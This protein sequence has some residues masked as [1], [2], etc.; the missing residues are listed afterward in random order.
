MPLKLVVIL[1]WACA[2]GANAY[3][4]GEWE[5]LDGPS[6]ARAYALLDYDGAVRLATALGVHRLQAERWTLEHSFGFN[7]ARATAN[8]AYDLFPDPPGAFLVATDTGVFRVA[9]SVSTLLTLS[10]GRIHAVKVRKNAGR[11]LFLGR[12]PARL[13]SSP[14]GVNWDIA[15]EG[16]LDFDVYQSQIWLLRNV[17]EGTALFREGGE[18][19]HFGQTFA[20]AKLYLSGN[21][22]AVATPSGL[23]ISEDG[24]QNFSRV[25][26]EAGVS[27]Y[28]PNGFLA[29]EDGVV[30]RNDNNVWTPVFATPVPAKIN[31]FVGQYMLCDDYFGVYRITDFTPLND[32]LRNVHV[33]AVGE[34]GGTVYAFATEIGMYVAGASGNGAWGKSGTG[35]PFT[36]A[37]TLICTAPQTAFLFSALFKSLY[38]TDNRGALWRKVEDFPA[39]GYFTRL[40][41]GKFYASDDSTLFV[42]DNGWQWNV[43]SRPGT[44]FGGVPSWAGDTLFIVKNQKLHY[45]DGAWR[46]YLTLG[47]TWNPETRVW[48]KSRVEFIHSR[49]HGPL[50]RKNGTQW[51]LQHTSV[52]AVAA[53]AGGERLVFAAGGKL[54][55]YEK[56]RRT[57]LDFPSPHLVGALTY[58]SD[59]KR[60]FVGTYEDGLYALGETVSRT[61]ETA[62]PW[63]RVYPNPTRD[64]LN[65][66]ARPGHFALI[67]N[68][69]GAVVDRFSID[70]SV[71]RRDVSQLPAGVY[72][73]QV[74][75]TR[76]RWVKMQAYRSE[77]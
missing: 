64:E 4:Q 77:P 73:L 37:E 12:N 5:G 29:T 58:S 51:T 8:A 65:I 41:D 28:S 11:F 54:Y 14:N 3:G 23:W 39:A 52:S 63:L 38:F 35:L 9:N 43:H 30:Y 62:A 32:G 70:A 15:S 55:Q 21:E 72:V 7:A 50:F 75:Q 25:G 24:G 16:V 20:E 2:V 69:D 46:E 22:V 66:E 49:M 18:V 53:F 42:S 61:P 10:L 36:D 6:G 31:A 71:C 47:A 34:S 33:K 19:F 45:F 76:L 1:L 67:Y 59:G 27:A 68:A 48:G 26:P 57:E 60:L 13:Y 17:V 44:G 40:G 74:G 56:D